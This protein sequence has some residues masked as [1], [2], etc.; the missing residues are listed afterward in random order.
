[1]EGLILYTLNWKLCFTTSWVYLQKFGAV[2]NQTEN[3]IYLARY[4]IE[5]SLVHYRMSRYKQDLLAS[6]ALFL[7]KKFT[8]KNQ[9]SWSDLLRIIT[10]YSESDLRSCAKNMCICLK[11][12]RE[13]S[14]LQAVKKKFACTKFRRVSMMNE[15]LE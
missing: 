12:S 3:T 2:T 11:I 10:D 13:Q 5:E 4:F 9:T 6:A 8:L 1:M 14:K 15:L 7:A